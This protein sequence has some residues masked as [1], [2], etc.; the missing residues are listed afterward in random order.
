MLQ[1]NPMSIMREIGRSIG[2]QKTAIRLPG[3]GRA[4][5]PGPMTLKL[6][7]KGA[8]RGMGPAGAA[9]RPAAPAARPTPGGAAQQGLMGMLKSPGVRNAAGTVG[10]AAKW[11]VPGGILL[12][13]LIAAMAAQNNMEGNVT[14]SIG[15]R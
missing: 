12:N 8:P 6:P 4:A 5:S 10:R 15:S 1:G 2:Q 3:M 11:G 9:P 14:Q 13:R 7:P